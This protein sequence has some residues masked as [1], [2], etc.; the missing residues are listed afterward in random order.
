MLTSETLYI[1][2]LYI[3]VLQQHTMEEHANFSLGGKAV[4]TETNLSKLITFLEKQHSRIVV[5]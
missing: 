2:L 5:L 4:V 1:F 3:F